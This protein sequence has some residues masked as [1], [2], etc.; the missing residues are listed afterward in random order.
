M[1][2]SMPSRPARPVR[3][4]DQPPRRITRLWGSGD[5][6][7]EG[8]TDVDIDLSTIRDTAIWVLAGV[9]VVGVLAAIVI[10]AVIG[11]VL[12]LIVAAVLVYV[13]LQQRDQVIDYADGV[14]GQ[15][16][17]ASQTFFGVEV[18]LPEAWCARV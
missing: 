11:K 17:G 13:G 6:P 7:G 5:S 10:K 9:A 12:A 16:C 15:V 2:A 1:A 14:R 18:A 4:G 3:D 8:I